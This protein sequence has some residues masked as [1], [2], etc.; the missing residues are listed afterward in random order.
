MHILCKFEGAKKYIIEKVL[1]N[2]SS[3]EST[4]EVFCSC[5]EVTWIQPPPSGNCLFQS[6]L[7]RKSGC[8]PQVTLEIT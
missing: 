3:V 6:Y 1:P 8:K 7:E 5:G 2:S 4:F